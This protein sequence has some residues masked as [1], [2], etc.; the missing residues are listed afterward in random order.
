[1]VAWLPQYSIVTLLESVVVADSIWMAGVEPLGSHLG[2][3]P[4]T[5]PNDCKA[6]ARRRAVRPAR[7]L[8]S[9]S[10]KAGFTEIDIVVTPQHRG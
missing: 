1:V 7:R 3:S 2:S 4:S 6:A 10:V 9:R 8:K 5:D